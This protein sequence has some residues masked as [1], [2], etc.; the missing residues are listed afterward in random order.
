[1]DKKRYHFS[2]WMG[3]DFSRE[4]TYT[5][6]R[7]LDDYDATS[8]RIKRKHLRFKA[9]PLFSVQ[10]YSTVSSRYNLK[11]MHIHYTNAATVLSPRIGRVLCIIMRSI[12]FHADMHPAEL[13]QVSI[14][15][16]SY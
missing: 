6:W 9:K 13:E 3:V 10:A 8:S 15:S 2:R 1:M 14:T 5:H 12:R 11:K 4:F 16:L 7:T